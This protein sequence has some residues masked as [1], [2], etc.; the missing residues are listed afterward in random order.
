MLTIPMPNREFERLGFIVQETAR[1][2]RTK[3]DQR[4]RPL[5]LSMGKWTTLVHLAR[6]GD[7]LTQ[8]EIA[9]RV[10]V[11]EPTLAGILNRLEEDGW[12]KRRSC[13]DDRRCKTVH[14]QKGSNAV[15]GQILETAQQLRHE[16]LHDIPQDDVETCFRVLATIR[17]RAS[18]AATVGVRAAT[19]RRNGNGV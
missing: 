3:L 19:E 8:A 16:L 17:D 18:A 9:A 15:L 5:G 14:L 12:I 11:E 10:G 6:G 1:V 13:A 4:L 2:W 7:K